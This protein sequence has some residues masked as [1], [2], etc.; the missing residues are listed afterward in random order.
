MVLSCYWLYLHMF[1]KEIFMLYVG[2]SMHMHACMCGLHG[3]IHVSCM[4]LVFPYIINGMSSFP[5][6]AKGRSR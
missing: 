1:I 6:Y 3:D 2:S 5:F 4:Y